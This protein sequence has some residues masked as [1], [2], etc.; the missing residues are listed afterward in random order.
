MGGKECSEHHNKILP[1]KN[2]NYNQKG[3]M[4]KKENVTRLIDN[5]YPLLFF[6]VFILA[7]RIKML[8]SYETWTDI[9]CFTIHI[10]NNMNDKI[11]LYQNY[12]Y[13]LYSY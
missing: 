1:Q 10:S 9:F 7:N 11:E 4:I 3:L 5:F 8:K 2:P 6:F 13:I 12:T